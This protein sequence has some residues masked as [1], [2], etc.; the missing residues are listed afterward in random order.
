MAKQIRPDL[1]PCAAA[2]TMK[3]KRTAFLESRQRLL[4]GRD[5]LP[6]MMLGCA[7]RIRRWLKGSYHVDSS[8]MNL[9]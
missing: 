9:L 8:I 7:V 5:A 6:W 2:L 1:E 3:V 4:D